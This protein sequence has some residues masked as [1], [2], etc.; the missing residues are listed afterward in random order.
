PVE[1]AIEKLTTSIGVKLDRTRHTSDIVAGLKALL[2]K[3][4]GKKELYVQVQSA[5]GAKVSLKVN[6]E[7][8]VRVTRDLVDDLEMLLGSGS[9]QLSGDGQRRMKRLSQQQLFKDSGPATEVQIDVPTEAPSDE[10]DADLA[11]AD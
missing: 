9:V 8:G 10:I 5:D 6:G 1:S 3:H 2:R 4:A 11:M 7:L